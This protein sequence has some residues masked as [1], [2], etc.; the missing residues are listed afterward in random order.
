MTR[1]NA[2]LNKI[3]LIG[4]GNIGGVLVQEIVR[5]RL[6]RSVALVDI[7]EP[8]LAKGK[9]LDVAE[10]TPVISS[11]IKVE[12]SK[13][14][15]VVEGAELVINTAGVPRTTRPDG[16]IPSREELLTINLK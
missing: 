11:D 15:A 9:T 12:G 8:E 7:K 5:R 14:Y 13:E 4:G 2:M 6:A 3:A 10:G 16:T 1:R